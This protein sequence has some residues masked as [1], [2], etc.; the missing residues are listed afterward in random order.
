MY[1]Q[2]PM[3][4][5]LAPCYHAPHGDVHTHP[6]ENTVL[7]HSGS[8]QDADRPRLY[9]EIGDAGGR[10]AAELADAAVAEVQAAVPSLQIDRPFGVTLGYRPVERLDGMPGQELSRQLF[11]VKDGRAY[12][13]IF[14]P[15]D[16][17]QGEAY[18]H[19]EALHDLVVKSFR[20]LECGTTC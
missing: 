10:T 8:L 13:L 7:I 12:R 11:A 6:S 17:G 9:I 5:R 1:Y 4:A 3:R 18:R 2:S 19:M 20:F 15:A 14:T 16:P